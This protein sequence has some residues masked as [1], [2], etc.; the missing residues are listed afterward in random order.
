MIMIMMMM[1]IMI[2]MIMIPLIP[3]LQENADFKNLMANDGAAKDI[4]LDVG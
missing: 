1:M 3:A 2:M 4:I